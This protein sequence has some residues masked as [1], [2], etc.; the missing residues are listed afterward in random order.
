[1]A[2]P[3]TINVRMIH[4]HYSTH[5]NLGTCTV[6]RYTVCTAEY[7]WLCQVIRLAVRQHPV[8]K[9]TRASLL[10]PASSSI[11]LFRSGHRSRCSSIGYECAPTVLLYDSYRKLLNLPSPTSRSVHNTCHMYFTLSNR[12]PL[13]LGRSATTPNTAYGTSFIRSFIRNRKTATLPCHY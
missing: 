8:H 10:N 3:G 5:R 12:G 4:L 9:S 6:Y 13:L 1:M 2:V 7:L 11:S